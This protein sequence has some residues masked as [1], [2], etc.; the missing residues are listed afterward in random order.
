L[1]VD[2]EAGDLPIAH[3]EI[4]SARPRTWPELRDLA[5]AIGGPNPAHA[6]GAYSQVHYD[7]VV[8]DPVFA[9][10]ARFNTVFVDSYTEL[11]RICRTWA[12]ARPES[13][14]TSGKQDMRGTYGLLARELIAWTQQLQHIRSR[15]IILTAILEKVTDDYGVSGWRPQIEGA[16]TGRELPAILDEILTMH[17]ITTAGGKTIRALLCQPNNSWRFPTKDRSGR[18]AMLEEPHLRKL[19]A[20]LAT[21]QTNGE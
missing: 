10:L 1:L 2:L 13:F 20:K 9:S 3:L 7:S 5:V 6:T 12:A 21:R 8:A 16:K 11:A 17:W 14:N 18:L 15:T 19:L 4:A